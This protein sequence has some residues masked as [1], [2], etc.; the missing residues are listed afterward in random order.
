MVDTRI[1]RDVL[2]FEMFWRRVHV[3]CVGRLWMVNVYKNEHCT[4]EHQKQYLIAFTC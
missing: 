2:C 3:E 1:G 4:L